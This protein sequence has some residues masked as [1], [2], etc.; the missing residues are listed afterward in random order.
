MSTCTLFVKI[1]TVSNFEFNANLLTFCGLYH[2]IF[3]LKTIGVSKIIIWWLIF[4]EKQFQLWRETW[5]QVLVT[6]LITTVITHLFSKSSAISNTAECSSSIFL[7]VYTKLAVELGKLYVKG[8]PISKVV[9]ESIG[10]FLKVLC[11]L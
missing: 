6:Y 10:T 1:W 9:P 5:I 11:L 3:A 2:L 8:T 4:E 7:P